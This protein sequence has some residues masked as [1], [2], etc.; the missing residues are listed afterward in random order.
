M[1]SN[2]PFKK[3]EKTTPNK[4]TVIVAFSIVRE[5]FVR[6]SLTLV[7]VTHR[8]ADTWCWSA[9]KGPRY[10]QSRAHYLSYHSSCEP[11]LYYLNLNGRTK[12]SGTWSAKSTTMT[13]LLAGKSVTPPLPVIQT[14]R[15]SFSRELVTGEAVGVA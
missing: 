10:E 7:Y 1:T 2:F 14:D 5:N 12:Q 6:A 3:K 4:V 8:K 15:L 9:A 13:Q 11:S